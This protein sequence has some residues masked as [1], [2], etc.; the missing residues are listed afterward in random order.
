[1][2]MA[3]LSLSENVEYITVCQ[4][5]KFELK[6]VQKL[7]SK[8]YLLHTLVL[9]IFNNFLSLCTILLNFVTIATFCSSSHLRKKAYYFL[10]FLQSCND[11]A[12]GLI[13]SPLFSTY[14]G[15]Y[16]VNDLNCDVYFAF[17][18]F[19]TTAGFSVIILSAMNLERYASIVHPVY[20]RNKF[21]K[22]KLLIFVFSFCLLCL[23]VACAS[24]KLSQD[25]LRQ[26]VGYGCKLHFVST[27]YLYTRIFLVRRTQ[28]KRSKPYVNAWQDNVQ[29]QRNVA[30]I[31]RENRH[32]IR[33]DNQDNRSDNSNELSDNQCNGSNIRRNLSDNQGNLP[34]NGE[35]QLY[36][37][38]GQ[39]N[40]QIRSSDYQRSGSDNQGQQLAVLERS[41]N[42]LGGKSDNQSRRSDHDQGN[43]A[44]T[45][46]NR[47]DDQ[48]DHREQNDQQSN[49][50]EHGNPSKQ[51]LINRKSEKEFLMKFKLAKSCLIVV[52]C[53]FVAFFLPAI[54]INLF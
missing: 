23:C 46:C 17:I 9:F 36:N 33:S 38:R 16:F 11:L 10:I 15:G 51:A 47:S 30:C 12:I 53:S 32:S 26:F 22:K 45:R 6:M 48:S 13:V 54:L 44:V 40:H 25:V 35:K 34:K 14:I 49:F 43:T 3:N 41:L 19:F 29:I 52:L 28:L 31:Y 1:M 42:N 24:V 39:S 37:H 5:E 2:K 18:M 20:H 8:I 27:I 50:N 4:T 7:P 21:T